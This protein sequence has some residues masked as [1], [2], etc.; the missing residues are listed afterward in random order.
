VRLLALASSRVRSHHGNDHRLDSEECSWYEED[1][2]TCR[3]GDGNAM[4]AEFRLLTADRR[5][6]PPVDGCKEKRVRGEYL[7]HAVDTIS[8]YR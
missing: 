1:I 7:N 2:V 5:V 6:N 8:T 3:S 4:P